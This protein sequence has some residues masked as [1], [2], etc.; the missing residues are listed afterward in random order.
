LDVVEIIFCE[1]LNDECLPVA[2]ETIDF[3]DAVFHLENREKI[4]T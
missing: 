1:H 3:S 2:G 4:K